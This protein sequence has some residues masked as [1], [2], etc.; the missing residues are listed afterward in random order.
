MIGHLPS[1]SPWCA[2]SLRNGHPDAEAALLA[3]SRSSGEPVAGSDHDVVLLFRELASGAWRETTV[4]EGEL[5]EAFA[6]D[7]GTLSYFCREIDRASGLPV[8]PTMVAEGIP[9]LTQPSAMLELARQIAA[10]T[11]RSG[12]PP[13]TVETI[14]ARRYAITEMAATLADD[15]GKGVAITVGAALCT[16]L[17]DFALRAA[18]RW[19]ATSKAIPRALAEMDPNLAEQ[20]TTAFAAL[21]TTSN[22]FPVQSLVETV[23]APYDGRLRAG[24]R[25]IAPAAWRI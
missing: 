19:S 11:L 14:G 7:L 6:H 8:L 20:F 17:A 10:E 1:R 5:I 16:A 23:L 3:G 2:V 22:A 4:F 18:G 21:F 13:L 15:R 24:Y 25:Q 12:P 9:A